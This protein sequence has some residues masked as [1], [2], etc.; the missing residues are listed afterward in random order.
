MTEQI[1]PQIFRIGVVLP[2]NPLK[3]L[4]S[5]VI[6]TN[7][8]NLLID[9]G[10][11]RPECLEA[12]RQGIAELNLDMEQTDIFLTH[13][14]GDHSGLASQIASPRSRIYMS[15]PDK[16]I[17][18]NFVSHGDFY[19]G[20]LEA[21]FLEEGFPPDE[22][23]VVTLANPGRRF[24]SSALFPAVSV[25]DG[26]V[27]QVGELELECIATPGHSPGHM[28]LYLRKEKILF[29]GDH[30]LF[31]ITPNISIWLDFSNP[32][33]RYFESL[34]AISAY[35]VSLCLPGH[36]TASADFQERIRQLLTHHSERLRNAMEIVRNQ[37]GITAYETAA[38]MHWDIRTKDW[39]TFPPGQKWFAVGEALTH[40]DY[41]TQ[42]KAMCRVYAKGCFR[43]RAASEEGDSSL[44]GIPE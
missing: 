9:T 39:T 30:I 33:A 42:A 3:A 32:L 2:N 24:I 6:K 4:N 7:R 19:W 38:Q 31:D 12:L 27:I 10:F 1:T 18:D 16:H 14:H 29:S 26:S 21:R 43:Y 25:A 5:Y 40:L 11:N 34:N 20:K 41:L 35:D 44:G 22:L 28:C 13:V 8:R 37:P 15:A 36:R 17:L 23:A